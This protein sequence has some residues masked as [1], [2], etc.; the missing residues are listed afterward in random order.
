MSPEPLEFDRAF[1]EVPDDRGPAD[2]EEIGGLLGGE[3]LRL[4]GYRHRGTVLHRL[5]DLAQ[6]SV[7]LVGKL[8]S[9][10]DVRSEEVAPGCLVLAVGLMC[11]DEF[12]DPGQILF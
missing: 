9:L 6:D 12:I 11:C 1:V 7:D 5:H 10:A 4:W 2:A 3:P 8:D